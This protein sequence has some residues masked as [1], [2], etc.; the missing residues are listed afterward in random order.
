MD[1]C[2]NEIARLESYFQSWIS[3]N[4]AILTVRPDITLLGQRGLRGQA[5]QQ[6]LDGYRREHNHLRPHETLVMPT[7]ATRWHPSPRRYGPILCAWDYAEGTWVLQVDCQ[8]KLV[9][10]CTKWRIGRALAGE[11]V[12]V[13][14]VEHRLQIYYC[15]TLTQDRGELNS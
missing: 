13:L 14:E 8:G 4:T 15:H 3:S 9:I 1:A 7:P 12:Q 10:R 6:W 5:P 11:W 2:T